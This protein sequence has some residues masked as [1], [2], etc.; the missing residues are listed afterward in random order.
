MTFFNG[1]LCLQ[2]YLKS[3][4]LSKKEV[5]IC[6]LVSNVNDRGREDYIPRK[7]PFNEGRGVTETDT[8]PVK[9]R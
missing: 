1:I 7:Q 8:T 3:L 6:E 4:N 5:L 9:R 2:E